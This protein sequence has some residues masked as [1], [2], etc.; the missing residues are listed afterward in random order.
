MRLPFPEAPTR[1]F[2]RRWLVLPDP[3][4]PGYYLPGFWNDHEGCDW[5]KKSGTPVRAFAKGRVIKRLF[6]SLKGWQLVIQHDGYTSGYNMLLANTPVAVGTEVEEGDIIAQV[7]SSGTASTGAHLHFEIKVD[8]VPIDPIKF[9]QGAIADTDSNP[10]PTEEDPLALTPE[11]KQ[12]L[13][14]SMFNF[15]AYTG[16]VS[17]SQALK[18]IHERTVPAR[19]AETV[20]TGFDVQ[21]DGKQVDALQ[22]LADSKTVGLR[23]E[24]RLV[25]LQSAVS[26]LATA[27]GLDPDKLADLLATRVDAAL[28]DNFA[29]V[30]DSVRANLKEA[31]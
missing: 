31:L 7:G 15:P 1:P 28:A 4:R 22:E 30:G 10:F 18:D 13:L 5:A 19:I 9:Y 21:R 2:G 23:N 17:F 29:A 8:G 14:D 25:A 12:E 20:W 11:Q 3:K 27:Q 16:G 26:T 6:T 24:A